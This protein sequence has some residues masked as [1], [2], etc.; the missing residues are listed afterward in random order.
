MSSE[1][2]MVTCPRC[3]VPYRADRSTCPHCTLALSSDELAST[4]PLSRMPTMPPHLSSASEALTPHH[5]VLLQALPSGVCLTLPHDAVM[6]LGRRATTEP[7]STPSYPLLS[8]EHLDAH[9]HGVSRHHCLLERRASGLTI[10]DLGST[11]GTYLNGRRLEQHRA[12]PLVHRDHLILGTLHLAVFFG[13][14]DL[15]PPS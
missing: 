13:T 14:A 4:R 2:P 8:L 11:N 15:Q 1:E 10:S 6:I 7:L 9:Q 5:V 3:G 12:Y